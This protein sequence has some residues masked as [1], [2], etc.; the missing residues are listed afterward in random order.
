LSIGYE[1]RSKRYAASDTTDSLGAIVLG[2]DTTAQI[3][4]AFKLKGGLSTGVYVFGLDALKSR[5]PSTSAFL[6][7]ANLGVAIDSEQ[8][9]LLPKRVASIE[10]PQAE[11]KPQAETEK[12]EAP[13][14][15]EAAPPEAAPEETAAPAPEKPKPTFPRLALD[16]GAGVYYNDRIKLAEGLS[17]IGNLLN[18]RVGAWGSIGYRIAPKLSLGGEVGFDF[19]TF[20]LSGTTMTLFDA[21]IRMNIR[22]ALGKIDLEAFTGPFI[23][24]ISGDSKSFVSYTDVDFGARVRFLGF[25][26]EASYVVSL[27]N[28]EASIA[29]EIGT[30]VSNYPRFGLGYAI[31]FK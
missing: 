5:G 28:T 30:I 19:A 29:D 8:I 22:Y 12:T 10:E 23:N 26:A 21:P 16:A 4:R 13:A 7:S 1:L 24:G 25:Y 14:E 3:N 27:R 31:K 9:R 20:R 15:A 6:F 18:T 11:A 17:A 2:L